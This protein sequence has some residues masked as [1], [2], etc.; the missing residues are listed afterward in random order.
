M[1]MIKQ[2]L[3]LISNIDFSRL[4]GDIVNDSSN[5]IKLELTFTGG[6]KIS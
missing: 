2:S 3:N 6:K 1:I 4:L 5:S